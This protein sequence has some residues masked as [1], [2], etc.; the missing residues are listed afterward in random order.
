MLDLARAADV[1]V[2]AFRPDR[3]RDRGRLRALARDDLRVR[4]E[5]GYHAPNG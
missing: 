3:A 1:A 2:Y 5:L 4:H